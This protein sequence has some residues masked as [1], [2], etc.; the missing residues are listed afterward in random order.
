M[1]L[2]KEQKFLEQKSVKPFIGAF[3]GKNPDHGLDG[4]VD[5][6]DQ[7]VGEDA[8]D[9]EVGHLASITLNRFFFVTDTGAKIS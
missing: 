7:R 8:V 2:A 9:V 6:A 1:Y 4:A 5:E 3:V